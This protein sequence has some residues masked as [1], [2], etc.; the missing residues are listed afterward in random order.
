[1]TAFTSA[2]KSVE[3]ALEIFDVPRSYVL[4]P[5]EEGYS[6]C[7]MAG[8][9]H[10]IPTGAAIAYKRGQPPAGGRSKN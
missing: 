4:K 9:R 7:C 6:P 3:E 2:E 8:A 10:R 1:M 5:G